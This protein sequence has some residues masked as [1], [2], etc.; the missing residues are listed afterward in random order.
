MSACCIGPTGRGGS[1]C[2]APQML[3]N[4]LP[5]KL[6]AGAGHCGYPGH[7]L[8]VPSG[9]GLLQG[10]RFDSVVAILQRLTSKRDVWRCTT[11]QTAIGSLGI[12]HN[13]TLVPS[14]SVA[15]FADAPRMS[16]TLARGTAAP[17]S[18]LHPCANGSAS[19]MAK[20]PLRAAVISH[21]ASL[22]TRDAGE[23]PCA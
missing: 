14:G 9:E 11:Q 4:R 21:A 7:V 8:W 10:S 12:S 1:D 23:A 5:A 2:L 19:P 18:G 16:G 20:K 6:L 13:A 3:N 15:R 22:S 17:A